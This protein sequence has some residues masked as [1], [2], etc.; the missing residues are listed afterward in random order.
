MRCTECGSQL[1]FFLKDGQAVYFCP[2]G[3]CP[4]VGREVAI[5]DDVPDVPGI[6]EVVERLEGVLTALTPVLYGYFLPS[7]LPDEL[8]NR[9]VQLRDAAKRLEMLSQ[10]AGAAGYG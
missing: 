9:A 2:A 7:E 4:A 1:D 6:D 3:E 5:S 8:A 10:A